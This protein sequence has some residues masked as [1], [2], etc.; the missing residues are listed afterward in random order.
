MRAV[1]AIVIFGAAL[2]SCRSDPPASAASPGTWA[3]RGEREAFVFEV[4]IDPV[5]PAVGE[6]FRSITTVRAVKTGR[7]IEGARFRLEFTMP[8]HGHGMMTVPEHR[9]LGG[10]R[11]ETRGLKLHMH[12]SW[13]LVAEVAREATLDRGSIVLEARPEGGF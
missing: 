8:H 13:T 2:L 7:P 11:Y 5:A 12:G 9:D 6:V 3:F 10:G 4:R 1:S